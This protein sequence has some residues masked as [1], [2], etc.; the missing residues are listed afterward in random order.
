MMLSDPEEDSIPLEAL[1]EGNL[2]SIV[3]NPKYSQLLSEP[4]G[5]ERQPEDIWPDD[6]VENEAC[7]LLCLTATSSHNLDLTTG[8]ADTGEIIKMY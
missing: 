2:R 7:I 8:P 1:S 4:L 5:N 6:S 3:L